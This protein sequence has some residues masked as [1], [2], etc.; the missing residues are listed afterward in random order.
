MV[1]FML[2]TS[3]RS[4]LVLF[5]ATVTAHVLPAQT[6]VALRIDHRVGQAEVMEPLVVETPA[7]ETVE[8][9]RLE[10]YL[11][12]F[13]VV[14]DGG[15]ETAIPEAYVL[16]DGFTDGLHALGSVSGV[17]NVE[18]LKFHVG[19]DP[20]NNHADPASW[21]ADHPLAPQV[22][23]MHWGWAAG[24][25][26]VALEGGTADATLEIHALGDDNHY[27]GETEV[28]ASIEN[29]TLVLDVEADVLGFFNLLTVGSGLIN[30]GEDAE[31]ILVCNNLADHVFRLPGAANVADV[32]ANVLDLALVPIENGA[33]LQFGA[34]C[35]AGTQLELL[36]LLG[37]SVQQVEVPQGVQRFRLTDVRPGAFLISV[38]T[39]NGR[40]TRRWIQG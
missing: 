40:T 25:R 8:I 5:V 30:H 6:N 32:T 7:G 9:D 3:L 21:P 35:P 11:S 19:I 37:R 36:D 38:Q 24:Y 33:E 15:Q 18:A 12:M 14:H 26:F 34:S 1:I 28:A 16:A 39:P 17:N 31:A 13:T 2:M 10:Y 29:G 4:A 22:P 27:P 23:S 20:D